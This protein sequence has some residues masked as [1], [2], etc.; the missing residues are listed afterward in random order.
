MTVSPFVVLLSIAV[1]GWLWG[2]VG[3]LLAVPLTVALTIACRHA[4][5]L[6]G[7]A[8]CSRAGDDD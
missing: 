4:P 7:V 6:G 1:W 8:A 2:A 3:A 5:G